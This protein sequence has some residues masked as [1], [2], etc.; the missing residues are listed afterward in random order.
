MEYVDHLP[1][2]RVVMPI[3]REGHFAW[4]I[5]RGHISPQARAEMLGDLRHIVRSGLWEQNWQPPQA[6]G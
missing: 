6:G 2:G 4:L 1:G 5:V 3:E